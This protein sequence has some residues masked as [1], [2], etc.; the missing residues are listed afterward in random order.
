MK[1]LLFHLDGELP[2]LALMRIARHHRELGD[3]VEL[4]QTGQPDQMLFGGFANPHIVYA[5]AIFRASIPT[6]ELAKKAFPSA[7]LGGTAIDPARPQE[8]VPLS[9]VISIR[10]TDHALGDGAIDYEIYPK[11][12]HSIGYSQRGCRLSCEFCC[13]PGKEGKVREIATINQ[14]WRGGEHKKNILL[15]DN[16]FFG[17]PRWRDRIAEIRDGRFKV[18]FSQGINARCLTDEASEAV[19]SVDYRNSKFN[20][21]RIYTAWDNRADEDRLFAGLG[22]LVKYGVK[23]DHIMVYMLCGFWPGE[24]SEDRDYRRR[25]LREFGARPYPMPYIKTPEL[26]GFQRWCVGAY[27]KDWTWKEWSENG[28]RPEGL[29]PNTEQSEFEL[30]P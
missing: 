5:S 20:T 26:V 13:V 7:L 9:P 11:F 10:H 19:A 3:D 27:D 1:V 15:L 25:R 16:D 29:A 4:R 24:T 23:P 28:Y 21:K 17:Q 2:N 12:E 8:I 6:A 22:R 30:C 14:I 18:S